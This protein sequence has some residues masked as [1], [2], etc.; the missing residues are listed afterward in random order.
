MQVIK[1]STPSVR[2]LTSVS[3]H[4]LAQKLLA[5]SLYSTQ[6]ISREERERERRRMGMAPLL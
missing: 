4:R 2:K 3:P 5:K 6:S 1:D